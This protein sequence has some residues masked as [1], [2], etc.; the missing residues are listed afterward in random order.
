MS[1]E[2]CPLPLLEK[3]IDEQGLEL[4]RAGVVLSRLYE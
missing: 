1:Y 3:N 2:L 4:A